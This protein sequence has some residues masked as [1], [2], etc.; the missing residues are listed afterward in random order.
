MKTILLSGIFTLFFLSSNAQVISETLLVAGNCE[1][2]KK[3][4]ETAV[5]LKGVKKASWDS[6]TK[7]LAIQ[8]DSKKISRDKIISAISEAGY[9]SE[10]MKADS[11]A[12]QKLDK[13]CQ[14]ERIE[15]TKKESGKP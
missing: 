11:A 8:Y 1:M 10:W 6:N 14:F 4:I 3:H 13:C 15:P 12:Y 2:C 7:Q 9:D 5:D